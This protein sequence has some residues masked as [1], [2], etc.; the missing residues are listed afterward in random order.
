PTQIYNFFGVSKDPIRQIGVEEDVANEHFGLPDEDMANS[1]F[2]S[3]IIDFGLAGVLGYPLLL[4][5]LGRL[6]L[7]LASKVLNSEGQ[8]VLI[9]A[10]IIQFSLS[11]NSI[12]GYL[13]ELRDI[14]TLGTVWWILDSL[15]TLTGRRH[16]APTHKAEF[17][18]D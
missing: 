2:S 6:L 15:P 7:S 5:F 13:N 18:G 10:M 16:S 11:E 17:A 3:G 12:G 4:C 1:I 8:I 14:A 9:L